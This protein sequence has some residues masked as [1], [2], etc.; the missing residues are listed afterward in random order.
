MGSNVVVLFIRLPHTFTTVTVTKKTN[1]TTTM[2]KRGTW[3]TTKN[4]DDSGR[5]GLVRR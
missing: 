1:W 4:M 2:T 3:R 5:G